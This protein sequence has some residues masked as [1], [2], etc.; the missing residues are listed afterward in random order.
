[1]T[2]ALGNILVFLALLLPAI[3]LALAGLSHD[4]RHGHGRPPAERR[5]QPHDPTDHRQETREP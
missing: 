2:G 4:I 1:M 5:R 3:I